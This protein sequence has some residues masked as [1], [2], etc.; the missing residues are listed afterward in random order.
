MVPSGWERHY[1]IDVVAR[2]G[3]ERAQPDLVL[4]YNMHERPPSVS[5]TH[6]FVWSAG[7]LTKLGS[8]LVATAVVNNVREMRSQ[9]MTRSTMALADNKGL[10][11]RLKS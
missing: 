9:H 5:P 3:T 7:Q 8:T 6:G 10:A 2:T 1:P 11:L 4:S